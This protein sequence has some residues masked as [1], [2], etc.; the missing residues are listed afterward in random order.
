MTVRHFINRKNFLSSDTQPLPENTRTVL[1]FED[2][3]GNL[4]LSDGTT[5]TVTQSRTN[6]QSYQNKT[7]DIE[8]NN[9]TGLIEYDP[10][11]LTDQA[12][13]GIIPAT[14]VQDSFYG[15][16]EDNSVT[17]YNP[18]SVI[19]DDIKKVLLRFKGSGIGGK[20]GFSTISPVARRGDNYQIKLEF[21]SNT[22]LVTLLGFTATQSFPSSSTVFGNSDIGICIGFLAAST[23][24]TIFTNDGAGSVSAIPFTKPKDSA[25]H[26]MEIILST[27]KAVC[28]LDNETIEVTT[29]LPPVTTDL[30][31]SIYGI[32]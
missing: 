31:L 13:G 6:S 14:T 7:F 26:I 11:S 30:Y 3:T 16:L 5:T 32:M 21:Q 23:F 15:I 20:L 18:D 8:K 22:N 19:T 2:D 28:K 25:F 10:F 17:L 24:F 9:I 27:T 1:M 29:K 4:L 12:T